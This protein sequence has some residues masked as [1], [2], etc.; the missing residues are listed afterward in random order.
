[1]SKYQIIKKIMQSERI[2]QD[3]KVYYIEMFIKGWHTEED[4]K[5]IFDF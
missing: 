4:L 2:N 1:M 3:D 5:W